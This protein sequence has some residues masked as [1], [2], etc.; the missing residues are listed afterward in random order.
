ML[1]EFSQLLIYA[2]NPIETAHY[3]NTF[4]W[5]GL[6]TQPASR[7]AN[8]LSTQEIEMALDHFASF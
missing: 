1:V 7:A 2:S 6:K 3:P 4:N 8:L 5:F